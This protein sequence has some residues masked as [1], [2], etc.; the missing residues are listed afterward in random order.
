MRVVIIGGGQA[1]QAFAD[2]LHQLDES[3]SI[4]LVGDESMLPYQRPPLS[5]A[6]LKDGISEE[7]LLLRPSAWYSSRSVDC[8]LGRRA[9]AIDRTASQVE[10]DDGS[11]LDYDRL[12]LCTGATPRRLPASIGGDLQGVMCLRGIADAERLRE[13]LQAGKHLLVVG[14][15]YIG[16]EA[17][18]TARQ[19]GLE[20]T[21][22]ELAER[23]LQRVACEQTAAYFRSAHQEAGVSIRERTGLGRLIGDARGQVVAAELDSGESLPV[24]LVLV[25]IG[26]QPNTALA[27]AAGLEI[28]GGIAVNAVGQTSD[29][30]IY[31]AGD[32]A[33]F[34]FR[35]ARVRLESVQNACDQPVVAATHAVTGESDAYAPTPWFWSD[36]YDISLQIAGYNLGYDQV[37]VRPGH[38]DGGLSHWYFADDRF[39]AVDA[40]NDSKA[41]MFGRKILES[42]KSLSPADAADAGVDLKAIWKS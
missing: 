24:D 1:G 19:L 5:K 14:G 40:I 6:F 18:A 10:L 32:C 17:A 29:S 11:R 36:Q 34:L 28:A 22:L 35:G 16:L 3:A 42:G 8:R 31:A 25:G 41:Y 30:A 7:K 13:T 20:V 37:V 33:S 27:E 23:I 15:G 2:R 9:V 21:V 26:V 12:A 39:I 4:V 38:R